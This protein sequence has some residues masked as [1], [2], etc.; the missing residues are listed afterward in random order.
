MTTK[1]GILRA[2]RQKCLDCSCHQPSEVK[3]CQLT[4]CSLWPFRMGNDP[5]PG[6]PRGCAKQSLPRGEVGDEQWERLA[7]HPDTAKASE[8]PLPRGRFAEQRQSGRGDFVN[9]ATSGD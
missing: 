1:A 7:T 3:D 6:A 9:G 5:C 2:I 4:A 8:P